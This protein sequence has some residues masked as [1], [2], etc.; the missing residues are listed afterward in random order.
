M[1]KFVELI[2]TKPFI[3][4][5]ALAV[6]A[7]VAISA[8]FI[9]PNAESKNPAAD[10]QCICEIEEFRSGKDGNGDYQPYSMTFHAP[11]GFKSPILESSYNVEQ[12]MLQ[13]SSSVEFTF[14]LTQGTNFWISISSQNYQTKKFHFTAT[15]YIRTLDMNFDLIDSSNY[16][17]TLSSEGSYNLL[18]LTESKNY[19]SAIR[20]RLPSQVEFS[21]SSNAQTIE[22][23]YE[24]EVSNDSVLKLENNTI[25]PKSLGNCT[26]TLSAT[27]G[28]EFVKK[29]KFKVCK[30][31]VLNIS[32]LPDDICINV[33]ESLSYQLKNFNVHPTYADLSFFDY[34]DNIIKCKNMVITAKALGNTELVFANQNNVIQHRMQIS[35]VNQTPSQDEE[36]DDDNN[37]DNDSNN[38]QDSAFIITLA[39]HSNEHIV[40]DNATKT[41]TLS[42]ADFSNNRGILKILISVEGTQGTTNFDANYGLDD[43]NDI[44]LQ[45]PILMPNNAGFVLM[46]KSPGTVILTI[47]N[48]ELGIPPLE[49]F[50]VVNE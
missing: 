40:F 37:N 26:I 21:V 11:Q 38:N 46:F 30:V 20:D 19:A 24:I 34:E 16:H 48:T 36:L 18:Y 49:I 17:Y 33:Q 43:P 35:V 9:F 6:V 4:I 15:P 8:I 2:K 5:I 50:I 41:F 10:I 31:P 39:E 47:Q 27:D 28:S 25:T 45:A 13:R 12:V 42:L 44:L 29:I 7:I 23:R 22:D 1:S 32:N 14:T 3:F